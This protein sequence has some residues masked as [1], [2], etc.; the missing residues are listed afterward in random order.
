M[1]AKESEVCGRSSDAY[2]DVEPRMVP[3]KTARVPFWTPV[4]GGASE[5]GPIGVVGILGSPF[6]GTATKPIARSPQPWNSLAGHTGW[7]P[8]RCRF[9]F[10]F[11]WTAR[12]GAMIAAL[13]GRGGRCCGIFRPARVAS[14]NTPGTITGWL[15]RES[16]GCCGANKAALA[17]V[18]FKP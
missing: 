11:F 3:M 12:L 5:T 10:L 4:D 7:T 14:I 18:N 17:R 9:T 15:S 16:A 13:S 6:A 8:G 2:G 1:G